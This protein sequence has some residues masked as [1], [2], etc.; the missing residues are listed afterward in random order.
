VAVEKSVEN[1]NYSKLITKPLR[2]E[3]HKGRMSDEG[4]TMI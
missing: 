4:G 1:L 3:G 2:H